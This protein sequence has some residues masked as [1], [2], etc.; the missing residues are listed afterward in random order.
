MLCYRIAY[1]VQPVNSTESKFIIG[2]KTSYEGNFDVGWNYTLI[3]F[4][5][6]YKKK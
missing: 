5:P 1:S 3:Y 6:L 2:C 4:I